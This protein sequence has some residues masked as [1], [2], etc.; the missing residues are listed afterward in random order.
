MSKQENSSLLST[1]NWYHDIEKVLEI[2]HIDANIR[3]LAQIK[4]Q[5][6]HTIETMNATQEDLSSRLMSKTE[7]IDELRGRVKKLEE[8]L[9]ATKEN[10]KNLSKY[11]ETVK[12]ASEYNEI[13]QKIVAA[14]KTK[15]QYETMISEL[16]DKKI[17][18]EDELAS[19]TETIT[20]TINTNNQSAKDL[21]QHIRSI[22]K[23]ALEHIAKRDELVKKAPEHILDTYND[24]SQVR[25][26]TSIVP[27]EKNDHGITS[28]G[29]CHL[30]IPQHKEN[31]LR[32][33]LDCIRCEH[34]ARVLHLPR[35]ESSIGGTM[36]IRKKKIKKTTS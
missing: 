11:Q 36:W 2:Q 26:H 20:N 5:H 7:E 1:T 31:L 33:Q 13:Y 10:V 8:E 9:H 12:K 18:A 6:K 15:Q 28:C 32:K 34:C 4:S 19:L 24:L 27:L 21:I 35:S 23:E 3:Q 22:N 14:Q 30:V 29:G 16:I 17:A 25:G